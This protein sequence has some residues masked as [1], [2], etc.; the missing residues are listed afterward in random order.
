V[1]GHSNTIPAL[2]RHLGIPEFAIKDLADTEFD[3]L[4]LITYKK[5][6]PKLKAMKYGSPSVQPA[7]Q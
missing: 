6:K 5:K 1:I 2:I 4:F 3:N 7:L